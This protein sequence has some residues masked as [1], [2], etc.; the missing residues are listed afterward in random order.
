VNKNEL[1][2]NYTRASG[3]FLIIFTWGFGG[4]LHLV[5]A[6]AIGAWY[7]FW[8]GVIALGFPIISS[9]W[10]VCKELIEGNWVYPRNVL[11]YIVVYVLMI[12]LHKIADKYAEH[13]R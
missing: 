4:L 1:I 12:S 10:V 13:L 8:W 11:A 5:A 2:R 9:F 3:C 6:M 7:G